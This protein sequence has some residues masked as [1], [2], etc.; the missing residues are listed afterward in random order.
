MAGFRSVIAAA[1]LIGGA[2]FCAAQTREPK[3]QDLCY[4]FIQNG[5]LR[6][7]CQGKSNTIP[8]GTK[9]NQFAVS[10]DGA[11]AA[12]ESDTIEGKAKLTVVDLKAGSLKYSKDVNP[13]F[14]MATCGRLDGFDAIKNERRNLLTGEKDELP[15]YDPS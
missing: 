2:G 9:L 13:T 4:A 12:L 11:Y 3:P 6:T 8:V 5:E 7:V 1:I 14:L 15:P 10:T